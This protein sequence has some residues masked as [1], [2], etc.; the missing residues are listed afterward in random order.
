MSPSSS[1]VSHPAQHTAPAL[2]PP[3]SSPIA[4][5]VGVPKTS[6]ENEDGQ[7][8]AHLPRMEGATHGNGGAD[9]H[10]GGGSTWGW[11]TNPGDRGQTHGVERTRGNPVAVTIWVGEQLWLL[12][13]Y[14][15]RNWAV[16]D[17]MD[18]K[19]PLE[20]PS[21]ISSPGAQPQGSQPVPIRRYSRPP[22]SPQHST[23]LSSSVPS[24]PGAGEPCID[25]AERREHLPALLA[26]LCNAP[27]CPIG[28]LGHQG[29]LLAHGQDVG[30]Q[31]HKVLLSR[32]PFQLFSPNLGPDAVVVP[33]QA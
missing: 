4:H 18:W 33:P 16:L 23:G 7:A 6:D 22:P 11:R 5:F 17:H 30:Y 31:D 32:A 20:I 9:P 2:T 10:D 21:A 14:Q 12:R 24:P 29:T 15:D 28:L 8:D 26:T 27:Q 13:F 19:G 1:Q 3:L 25:R